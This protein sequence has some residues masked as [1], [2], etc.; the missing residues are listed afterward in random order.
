MDGSLQ[1]RILIPTAALFAA[2]LVAVGF[3]AW[4]MAKTELEQRQ[5]DR[6]TI[7]ADMVR[8]ALSAVMLERGPERVPQLLEV[9]ASR[10][11]DVRSIS[12]VRP[13]GQVA[14]SSQ[15][16][17]IGLQRWVEP[18][19][20]EVL[21]FDNSG[22]DGHVVL[23]PVPNREGCAGCHGAASKIN[24]WVDIHFSRG[25]LVATERQVA[26]TLALAGVPGFLVLVAIAWWLLGREAVLPLQRI[27]RAMHAARD[28]V[29]GVCADEG[30][31]DE[32]GHA[33]RRFDETVAALRAAHEQLEAMYRD[34]ITRADRFAALGE[35]ATGLAHEIKNPLSGLSGALE[36]LADRASSAPP[37]EVIEE[38]Q[39][40]VQRLAGIMESLLRYA[41]PSRPLLRQTDVNASL[42]RAIFL[43][44]PPGSGG[45]VAVRRELAPELPPVMGDASQLEQVFLNLCLNA[46]QAMCA[47]GGVLTVRS[48]A[49]AGEV[50]IEVLDTGPGIAPEAAPHVFKPFF[51]TKPSGSGL[52][53]AIVARLVSDHDGQ[54][55]CHT[56]TEGGA[57][58]VVRL[59]T[60][61]ALEGAAA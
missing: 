53:L 60:R 37:A 38:M 41:R 13:D 20:A 10:G 33:A 45:S 12:L 44:N 40:Q 47:R 26:G 54:I 39:H 6:A 56:R 18:P 51:T 1:A 21:T 29:P 46:H 17:L 31:P 58:F 27:V 19:R 25:R 8:E 7:F 15:P 22:R 36:V 57:A 5:R 50:V 43:V 14:F 3:G 30:R 23:M 42:E 28:G 52:G 35:V 61:T 48:R 55:S 11:E 59:P 49:H 24:G 4:R 16:A 34:Q 2:T 9:L 32:L